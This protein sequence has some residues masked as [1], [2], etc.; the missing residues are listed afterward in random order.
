MP[1][2]GK[3]GPATAKQLT[4]NTLHSKASDDRP[5]LPKRGKDKGKNGKLATLKSIESP[6]HES[7]LPSQRSGSISLNELT[8]GLGA[9]RSVTGPSSPVDSA[10]MD[11]G[12]PPHDK[13]AENHAEKRQHR[14]DRPV[15]KRPM[16]PKL[17]H[18]GR[19]PRPTGI[20][21]GEMPD[22]DKKIE[23]PKEVEQK[24]EQKPIPAPRRTIR[25]PNGSAVNIQQDVPRKPLPPPKKPSIAF[26]EHSI[27]GNK[28]V[29]PGKKPQ[30]SKMVKNTKI[31]PV[32]IN[33]SALKPEL[34]PVAEELQNLYR[35]ACD[36]ITLTDARISE[37]I[38][39]KSDGCVSIASSLLDRLSAYRDSLGPVT[40]MK[41]N[42]HITSLE[43]CNN[44][45]KSLSSELPYSPNAVELSRLC[46]MITAVVDVIETLSNCLSSL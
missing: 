9:L 37:N 25:K 23:S 46:K 38:K 8:K 22:V 19:A 20:V 14:V 30:L 24:P 32:S 29:V 45:L 36:I 17:D 28:P 43:E 1:L 31:K 4:S 27:H 5:H 44:E 18:S 41:V 42:N 33:T 34:L 11:I 7:G 3:H 2:P 12:S 15:P 10:K 40:R 26:G 21:D 39:E 16:Q 6:T 13:E 35:S